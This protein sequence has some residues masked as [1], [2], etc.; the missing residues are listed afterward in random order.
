MIEASQI[1]KI[2]LIVTEQNPDKLGRTVAELDVSKASIVDPKTKFSM[3]TPKVANFFQHNQNLKSVVLFGIEAH[4]CIYQTA[5]DFLNQ[6]YQVF[7]VADGISSQNEAE[8]PLALEQLRSFGAVVSSSDS[9]I[10]QILGDAN[11]PDFK[12]ISNLVKL[13]SSKL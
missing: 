10:F 11:H 9:L 3:Y 4:V 12:P 13:H 8:V 1:L 2:P 5:L 7:L 6:N